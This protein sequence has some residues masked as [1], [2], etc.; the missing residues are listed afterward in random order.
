MEKYKVKKKRNWFFN[1][2]KKIVRLFKKKPTFIYLDKNKEIAD[3]SIIIANHSAAKGPMTYELFFPKYYIPWGTYEMNGGYRDRWKYLYYVFYQQ[4]L[5]LGKFKSFIVATLFALFS[6]MLYRS[7]G[8][9]STYKDNRIFSTFSKSFKVLDENISILIY[10]EDSSHGYFD[11]P[12]EYFQ[13]FASLSKLY[14]K[15]SKIDVPIYNVYFSKKTNKMI[16]DKPLYINKMLAEKKDMKEIAE[17]FRQRA[18]EL[19]KI[20]VR[21][22]KKEN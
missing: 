19:Y 18:L 9:I 1:F 20:Y 2:L 21:E 3:R 7:V 16:I 17:I 13:G 6:K 22:E 11:M 5:H 8:L 12:I 4:K 10:P 15:K 14:F